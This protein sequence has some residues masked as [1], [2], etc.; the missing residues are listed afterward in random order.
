ITPL[1]TPELPLEK[2][3]VASDSGVRCRAAS[4]RAGSRRAAT[5]ARTFASPLTL[6]RTSA[7]NT[8]PSIASI[9]ALARNTLEVRMVR[10][11]HC[12]KRRSDRMGVRRGS[13]RLSERHGHGIGNSLG[14]LPQ[15]SAAFKT[16]N[17]GPQTIQMDGDYGRVQSVDDLFQA[18]FERQKISGAADGA[19]G[20]NAN[21]VTCFQFAPRGADGR[22]YVPRPA[23]AHRNRLGQ[24]EESIQQLHV[25]KRL[26]HHVT[27]EALNAGVDQETVDVRHVV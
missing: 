14:P 19:F 9:L 11:P 6:P 27:Y 8:A 22:N 3:T 16:E 4:M 10:T 2:M 20:K 15:E 13:Y 25:V 24:T 26:P 21:H 1:G 12:E 18:A 17:A 5:R 7:R 23:G